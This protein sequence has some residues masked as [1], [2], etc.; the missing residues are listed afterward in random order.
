MNE[1]LERQLAVI[2]SGADELIGERGLVEKLAAGKPLRVKLGMDPTAPDLHFGHT[3]VLEK[4]RQFQELG[5]QVVFVVGDFTAGIGDPSGKNA[6]RPPL[7]H[8]RIRENAKT[9]ETQVF[10]VL[11]PEKTEIRCNSEWMGR[12][13]AAD[14]VRLSGKYT[15]ARMLERDDFHKRYAQGRAIA[16]HE[17]LYPLTQ[18][19]DSV[20][21]QA[22]VELGGTDQKFNLLVGRDIQR[23]YG[24]KAQTVLTMPILEG[25][26]GVNKMSKSLGNYIGVFEAPQEMFGKIMSLSD[27]LMWRYFALLSLRSQAAIA[28]LK[29]AVDAGK[30]P[31]DVKFELARE[32]VGRFHDRNAAWKAQEGFVARFAKNKIPEDLEEMEMTA[33][34][35][36]AIAKLLERTGLVKSASEGRRMIKQGAVRIDGEKIND[37]DFRFDAGFNGVVAVGKRRMA[38]VRLK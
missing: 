20:A 30:N 6:T 27:E 12:M 35:G 9:Y 23:E 34:E 26:D 4:L 17:F 19:Y 16:V 1:R 10:K 13:S 21:L 5:H 31:R 3:V 24:Q 2:R 33:G 38:R 28:G 18:A 32:L 29:Q 14:M 22:D 7:S 25:L 36:L 37:K 8:E 15:V 11:D